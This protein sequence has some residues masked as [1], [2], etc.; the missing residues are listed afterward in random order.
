MSAE[1]DQT[2]FANAAGWATRNAE[3]L[4]LSGE[5]GR[6]RRRR[7]RNPN[8]LILTGHGVSIRV[9]QGALIIRDGFTHY[10]Q[11]Q[12]RHRFFPGDLDTP[13]RILV[14]DGSGTLSFDVLS[15]L[16]EQ[17]VTLTR[18]KWTGEVASLASP[19]GYAADAAKVAWQHETRAD[20][21]KRLTFAADLI[22]RKLVNSIGLLETHFEQSR[23]RDMA[24]TKAR[25]GMD[26]LS[27]QTFAGIND[28]FAVEGECAAAYFAAWKGMP[29]RWT[30]TT[31]KP[32]PHSWSEYDGRSSVAAGVKPENRSASHPVNALLNYAYAVKVA[33]M[34][35]QSV[36]DGYDPTFGIMH[37][38]RRGKP[39][40][41]L[42]MIEPERPLV[43]GV[44]LSLV[45]DRSFT[46]ADFMIRKDGVCR[47]SPQ[48]ARMVA[49]LLS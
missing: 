12:V 26:R 35:V 34:Q 21:A 45:R 20:P 7:E 9:E 18:V 11:E 47:L 27:S 46:A 29:I 15:W 49:G 48:L 28:V 30:G 10:P 41:V 32:V 1:P 25:A 24:V 13:T 22:R 4:K 44:I 42:D 37:N 8:P 39:A 36:A 38:G 23:S 2:Q 19:T 31:R 3:W 16:G 5:L 17:G 6:K 14:L 43:D 33:H 40:L